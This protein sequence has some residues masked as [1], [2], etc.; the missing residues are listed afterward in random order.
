MQKALICVAFTTWLGLLSS[1]GPVSLSVANPSFETAETV[2]GFA[3]TFGDWG[4]DLSAIVP[5]ENG[6]TPLDGTS[7]LKFINTGISGGGGTSADVGQAIDLS[8]HAAL[9]AGGATVNASAY[10]NRVAGDAQT[11]TQFTIQMRS[12]N[13]NIV[14]FAFDGITPATAT[15]ERVLDQRRQYFDLGKA[16]CAIAAADRHDVHHSVSVRR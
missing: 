1:A 15:S 4:V 13:T 11:D 10:F 5:A 2:Q 9:I 14:L 8:S 6:I 3:P 12:F 16:D 7:M